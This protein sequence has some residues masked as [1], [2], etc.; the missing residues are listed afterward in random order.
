MPERLARLERLYVRSAIY[1]V[2]A[3]S[4]ERKPLLARAEIH[5]AFLDFAKQGPEHGA[6][7]GAYVLMPDHFHAFVALDDERMTLANWTRS[8]KGVL[9]A[10]PRRDGII[11]PYWQK[12]F[13]DHLLRSEESAAQKWEY[14]RENPV[15][16]RLVSKWSDWP[17]S[18]EVFPLEHRTERL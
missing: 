5:S 11:A 13:F 6:W 15:R 12:G 17:Y 1:F 10:E 2:T 16:A 3:C 4:F 9:S 14:V 7:I 18:G 8:L